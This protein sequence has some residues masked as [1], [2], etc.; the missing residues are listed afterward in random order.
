MDDTP[1]EEMFTV[2]LSPIPVDTAF[3]SPPRG[4]TGFSN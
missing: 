4:G 2:Q 1:L 3:L